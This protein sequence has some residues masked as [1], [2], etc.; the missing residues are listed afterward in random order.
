MIN[1]NKGKTLFEVVIFIIAFAVIVALI[2]ILILKG[3]ENENFRTLKSSISSLATSNT[4]YQMEIS[5]NSTVSLKELIDE[6]IFKDVTNPF[7]RKEKCDIYESR[8]ALN[9]EDMTA[10]LK[11]G[12][13]LVTMGSKDKKAVVYKVGKWQ[14]EKIE[15]A[16]TKIGYN[17]MVDGKL[18]LKDYYEE[19]MFLYLF[20]KEHN[21]FYETI[22]E[23]PKEYSVVN[24]VSYRTKE[25]LREI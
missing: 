4:L 5:D 11:C 6:K 15:N 12:E 17:Y 20:N 10:S 24:Q 13:Y 25:K 14:E 23:L 2:L 9:G 22:D 8:V 7:K 16:E 3:I 1:N 19:Y 18:Q 21:T